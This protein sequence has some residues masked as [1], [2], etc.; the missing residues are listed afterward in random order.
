M[1]KKINP[2]RKVKSGTNDLATLALAM[3]WYKC[4]T[5]VI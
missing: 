5:A 1:A 3:N 2:W 4:L